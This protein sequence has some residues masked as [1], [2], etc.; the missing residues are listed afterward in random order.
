MAEKKKESLLLYVDWLETLELV[1]PAERGLI[2]SNLLRYVGKQPLLT[3]NSRTEVL[4]HSILRQVNWDLEK[5]R[6]TTEARAKA[7]R[8]GGLASGESRREK[9][10]EANE[11]EYENEPVYENENAHDYEPPSRERARGWE[12]QAE[13]DPL[14]R[15]YCQTVE[16]EP[17][18]WVLGELKDY[19]NRLG[20]ELCRKAIAISGENGAV[21]W[22]YVRAVLENMQARGIRSPGQIQ[23]RPPRGGKQFITAEPRELSELEK[24]AVAMAL[25]GLSEEE[26]RGGIVPEG[27]Q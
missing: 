4:F 6:K 26:R 15:L 27:G 16:S 5:W 1:K 23:R 12:G 21:S 3:M 17:A 18:D 13:G 22:Q 14:I 25:E 10:R 20:E 11:A 24:Q 8:K 9:Q 19:R 7:G 2:F